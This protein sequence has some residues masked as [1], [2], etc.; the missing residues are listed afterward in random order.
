MP[1]LTLTPPDHV[2]L[3]SNV[4]S[5]GLSVVFPYVRR[6]SG[7]SAVSI[8]YLAKWQMS[9]GGAG[10]RSMKEPKGYIG[11]GGKEIKLSVSL[12]DYMSGAPGG[13]ST[14]HVIQTLIYWAYMT[15]MDALVDRPINIHVLKLQKE[16]DPAT[17][18][19]II[20]DYWT[21]A[22]GGAKTKTEG[23]SSSDDF[24]Y[25][26]WIKPDVKKENQGTARRELTGLD[27][28]IPPLPLTFTF[29]ALL[30]FPCVIKQMRIVIRRYDS[31]A[32]RAAD[33]DITLQE[34]L[35][36]SI[37]N[38]K[39]DDPEILL[40]VILDPPDTGLIIVEKTST[41]QMRVRENVSQQEFDR[42]NRDVLGLK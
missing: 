18:I 38:A 8:R 41:G 1:V 31:E 33:I 23:G 12:N 30:V 32:I 17:Q 16:A 6:Q 14:Q 27:A 15:T 19:R 28:P 5:R 3:P 11:Y 34:I 10:S 39:V 37:W 40:D 21:A 24:S 42:F 2:V 9:E 25:E 36:R 13:F 29:G 22:K 26:S 35:G 20:N 7:G 4:A